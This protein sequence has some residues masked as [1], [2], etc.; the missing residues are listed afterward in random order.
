[1]RNCGLRF[2][3]LSRS[4]LEFLKKFVHAFVCVLF[5]FFFFVFRLIVCLFQCVVFYVVV[6]I[7]VTVCGRDQARGI[8]NKQARNIFCCTV[9][10]GFFECVFFLFFVASIFFVVCLNHRVCLFL[11]H[12]AL[13]RFVFVVV[14]LTLSLSA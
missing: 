7:V 5:C 11:M 12:C 3:C 6:G 2:V 4:S 9:A 1:M 14:T 8:R 10:G 13:C